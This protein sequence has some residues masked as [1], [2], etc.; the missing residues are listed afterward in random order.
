MPGTDDIRIRLLKV[1]H[2]AQ[3]GVGGERDNAANAD[4]LLNNSA[5]R[6]GIP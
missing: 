6:V 3:E 5:T 4:V 2:L 1:L